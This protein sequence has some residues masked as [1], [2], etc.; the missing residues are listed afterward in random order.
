MSVLALLAAET[1][2]FAADVLEDGWFDT[3]MPVPVMYLEGNLEQI[4]RTHGQFV[5][6]HPQGKNTVK[7]LGSMV[8]E[9]L[10]KS[11]SLS[12]SFL[13]TTVTMLYRYFVRDPMVEHV[14]EHYRKA[15]AAF[16]KASGISE[17]EVLDALVTPDAA[18]RAVSLLYKS[19]LAPELAANFGCTSVI[20]DS[21]NTSA[22]HGRN[23]DYESVGFWDRNQLIM[24]IVPKEGLAHVAVTALGVHSTGITA[25]NEAGLTLAIHQFTFDDTASRGTPMPVIASEVIRFSRNIND[26]IAIIRSFP[27][28]GGWAYVLSQGHDRAIVEASA[29]DV[30]VRRSSERFFYQTNH[31]SSPA[32]AKRQVFYTPGSWL[33]S[34]NRTE[35][36]KRVNDRGANKGWANAQRVAALLGSYEV[37]GKNRVA[38]TTIA[39]LDNVQSVI[40][41]ASRRRLWIAVGTHEK[42]PNEGHYVEYRWNDLRS[43]QPPEI[44]HEKVFVN[45]RPPNKLRSYLRQVNSI[46]LDSPDQTRSNLLS[47]YVAQA[48]NAPGS[49]PGYFLRVWH[50]LKTGPQTE[51]RAQ[52]LLRVL[53]VGLSDPELVVRSNDTQIS[54]RT[55]HRV[56]L[57]HLFRGRLLDLI[58]RR[59]EAIYEYQTAKRLSAFERV[60]KA[61]DK[62]TRSPYQWANVK[63]I[64]IDWPGIDLYA[65]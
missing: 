3:S 30:A 63:N 17:D 18:L 53:D 25:F 61:A 27:R 10:R 32:L 36:L 9:R 1:Q 26:A 60:G 14:P 56:S 34:F 54:E 40:M 65:Y 41:D 51:E 59:G 20:W 44:G 19:E 50:E 22:L 23:L 7:Q 6:H 62:N 38:G 57:G 2:T 24:H 35:T 16:A 48:G 55:R 11:E 4:A 52:E 37:E 46:A 64:A 43:S 45:T 31:V 5:S 12:N 8:E 13:R 39:K 58:G 15:Y 28:A 33:D 21:S 47:T 42:A 49:W 29:K